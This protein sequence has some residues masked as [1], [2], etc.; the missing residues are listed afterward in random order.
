MPSISCATPILMSDPQLLSCKTH[1]RD[2]RMVVSLGKV[3][4]NTGAIYWDVSLNVTSPQIPKPPYT[5]TPA[6]NFSA[7]K[8]QRF[9][10]GAASGRLKPTA[11]PNS[12]GSP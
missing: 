5:S 4:R 6:A 1:P 9:P 12:H 10:V 2:T 7:Q 3:Q 8:V 11:Y